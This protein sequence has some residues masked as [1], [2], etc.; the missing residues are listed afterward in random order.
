MIQEIFLKKAVQIRKEYL[1]LKY[2]IGFYENSIK[3][4]LKMIES[5]SKEL[6]DFKEDLDKSK[7]TDAD[8]AKS[9]LLKIIMDIESEYNNSNFQINK[10]DKDI[11]NLRKEEVELFKQ[12]KQRYPEMND[13]DIK[14]EVQNY[15]EKMNLS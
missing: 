10:I 11:D 14:Q 6:G 1:K 5:K 9:R 7:I 4:L 2:D 13:K 8:V 15:I 3:D 12:I